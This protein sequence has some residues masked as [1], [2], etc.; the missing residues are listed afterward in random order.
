MPGD[1]AGALPKIKT[2]CDA[3][4]LSVG[5]SLAKIRP[6]AAVPARGPGTTAATAGAANSPS[7][8]S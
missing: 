3:Q 6:R 1:T 5:T 4:S 7:T 8:A 2:F